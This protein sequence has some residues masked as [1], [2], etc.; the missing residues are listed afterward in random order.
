MYDLTAENI[1]DWANNYASEEDLEL[2][3]KAIYSIYV[4]NRK[5]KYPEEDKANKKI[6]KT[7]TRRNKKNN[8]RYSRNYS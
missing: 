3:A 7:F 4:Q 2:T 6:V 5:R 1:V 8:Y